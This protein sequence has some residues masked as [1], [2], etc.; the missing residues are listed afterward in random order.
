[1]YSYANM[2][3]ICFSC[4]QLIY[5]DIISEIYLSVCEYLRY[6]ATH[7]CSQVIILCA[8][9]FRTQDADRLANNLIMKNWNRVLLSSY[10]LCSD[11]CLT[12]FCQLIYIE[13]N[14]TDFTLTH[15]KTFLY[16]VLSLLTGNYKEV[17]DFSVISICTD[18]ICL[19]CAKKT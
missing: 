1:M 10:K 2:T 13:W 7:H 19:S 8:E 16:T 3:T 14:K 17:P 11:I 9:K 6:S 12:T 15:P 4:L 5:D 18:C